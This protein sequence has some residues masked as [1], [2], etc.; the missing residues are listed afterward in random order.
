VRLALLFALAACGDGVAGPPD[1]PPPPDAGEGAMLKVRYSTNSVFEGQGTVSP[2]G[3][4]VYFLTPSGTLALVTQTDGAGVAS[5]RMPDGGTIVVIDGPIM[6]IYIGAHP[7]DEILVGTGTTPLA[8]VPST[9]TVSV[10]LFPLENT[11]RFFL[12]SSCPPSGGVLFA[13]G[14]PNPFITDVTSAVGVD[15]QFNF[16]NCD[17]GEVQDLLLTTVDIN[18]VPLGYRYY[19]NQSFANATIPHVDV[20]DMMHYIDVGSHVTV[21]NIG[22]NVTS[23]AMGQ[24]LWGKYFL[25]STD[26]VFFD[27]TAFPVDGRAEKTLPIPTPSGATLITHLTDTTN[28]PMIEN[29][30]QWGP[31]SSETSVDFGGAGIAPL[32]TPV[33]LDYADFKLRWQDTP[34][35]TDDPT[36][37]DTV[38]VT[39]FADGGNVSTINILAPYTVDDA[40]AASVAL[41]R[42]AELLTTLSGSEFPPT[43]TKLRL[44][45]HAAR[46]E[47]LLTG[48]EPFPIDGSVGQVRYES[49]R[50]FSNVPD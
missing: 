11:A 48:L 26:E 28:N 22:S 50:P 10:N 36:R 17:P 38:L 25:T 6:S 47:L 34:T 49:P 14:T 42:I 16:S 1:A 21:N 30:V 43:L 9:L 20:D 41:P 40:G 24:Q 27:T 13:G 12:H 45:T 39:M 32:I 19:P 35:T 46:K 3:R 4:R 23:F 8:V 29:V 7:G 2:A 5:A 31:A 33:V 44:G 15:T 37:P 18:N